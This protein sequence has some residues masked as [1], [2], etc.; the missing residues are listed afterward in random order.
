VHRSFSPVD[1]VTVPRT[2]ARSAIA[3]GAALLTAAQAEPALPPAFASPVARLAREF[4]ALCAALQYDRE[5]T[6]MGAAASVE[7]DRQLDACWASTHGFLVSCAKLG[8][9]PEGAERAARARAVLAVVFPGGLRFLTLPYRDQWAESETKLARLAE[10][11][12]AEHL[13]ALGGEPFV[14]VVEAAHERYGAAL[15]LTQRKAEVKARAKPRERLD[16]LLGAVRSYALRVASYLDEHEGD[17]EARRLGCA[18]LEPLSSWKSSGGGRKPQAAAPGAG[19]P[20]PGLIDT[21][22]TP[23]KRPS[24]VTSRAP[25]EG[26]EGRPRR[27]LGVVAPRAADARAKEREALEERD[28]EPRAGLGVIDA[29]TA[30]PRGERGGEVVVK[31]PERHAQPGLRGRERPDLDEQPHRAGVVVIGE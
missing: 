12:I 8:A 19:G 3:L 30:Q 1:L 17:P 23:T 27:D 4:D 13:R 5:A 21:R 10:P 7:A 9:A 24:E 6:S 14:R 2:S 18:L 20:E 15:H 29:A 26:P 16:G 28:G 11:E 25:Q 31:G 22:A